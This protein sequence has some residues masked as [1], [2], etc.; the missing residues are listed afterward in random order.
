[1]G[2]V[3]VEVRGGLVQSVTTDT[4]GIQLY[5]VHRDILLSYNWLSH[6]WPAI[7]DVSALGGLHEVVEVDPGKLSGLLGEIAQECDSCEGT[8]KEIAEADPQGLVD[9]CEECEGRGWWL[10]YLEAA[11]S[12][13]DPAH[14]PRCEKVLGYENASGVSTCTCGVDRHA[15][16]A[17]AP[18]QPAEEFGEDV[19]HHRQPCGG[20]FVLWV[21]ASFGGTAF[22]LDGYSFDELDRDPDEEASLGCDRCGFELDFP[23]WQEAARA[24]DEAHAGEETPHPT[25]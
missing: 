21:S 24:W 2:K 14:D 20:E 23:T 16:S 18:G 3:V 10:P 13:P 11:S 19:Y 9:T 1:M 15:P 5:V 25:A 6:I 22:S 12:S 4:P 8:G 17:L 7:S